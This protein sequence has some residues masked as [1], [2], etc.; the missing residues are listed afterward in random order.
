MTYTGPTN[1][2]GDNPDPWVVDGWTV[3]GSAA[4]TALSTGV[5]GAGY[6]QQGIIVNESLLTST[7][8]G[9]PGAPNPIPGNVTDVLQNAV[10]G[11][12]PPS[13]LVSGTAIDLPSDFVGVASARAVTFTSGTLTY[14]LPGSTTA[15]T[16]AT[17]ATIPGGSTITTT[18]ASVVT[19]I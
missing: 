4:Q 8:N 9:T 13:L 19:T 11:D 10:Y 16:P 18:A 12:V 7:G 6:A 14:M 5:P 17:G 2:S 1:G 15:V 3:Q